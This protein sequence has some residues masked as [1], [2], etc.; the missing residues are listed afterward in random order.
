MTGPR[1]EASPERAAQA[2]AESA[3]TQV[4]IAGFG[5]QGIVLA[6][7]ILGQAAAIHEGA[8]AV[9]TQSYGPE[10]RGGACSADVIA[11]AARIHYPRVTRPDILVLMSEEAARTYGPKAAEDATVLVNEDL[12]KTV[13]EGAG[14]RVFKIP[15][16]KIAESLGRRIMA[17]IVMLGFV[18]AVTGV[19]SREAMREAV[20]QNIPPGTEKMNLAAF[21]AGCEHGSAEAGPG[22]P[23][24]EDA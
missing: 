13:P 15:A 8:N 3:K 9:M 2:L 10:A 16:T 4:R 17:N 18:S 12:V 22:Q 24:E 21:D 7:K 11:S 5:G 14:L 23:E 19:V 1:P 20:L 6:G